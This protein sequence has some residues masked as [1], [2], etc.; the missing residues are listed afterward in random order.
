MVHT[1]MAVNDL[2]YLDIH[3]GWTYTLKTYCKRCD[4][5]YDM[6][7]WCDQKIGQC[8]EDWDFQVNRFLF[9]RGRDCTY[10]ILRW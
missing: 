3:P 7:D 2:G 10:F 8:G 4:D 6:F 5:I 9:R 1:E